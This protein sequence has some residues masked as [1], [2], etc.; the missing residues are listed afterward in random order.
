MEFYFRS[1]PEL[2][3]TVWASVLF[4]FPDACPIGIRRVASAGDPAGNGSAGGYRIGLKIAVCTLINHC[5]WV[6]DRIEPC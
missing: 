2:V 1:W 6:E 5:R 3:G 4:A